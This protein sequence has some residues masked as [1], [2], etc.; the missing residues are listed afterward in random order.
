MKKTAL[1]VFAVLITLIL[2]LAVGCTEKKDENKRDVAIFM[3]HNYIS[4]GEPGDFD[5]TAEMFEEHV[6]A[7]T[8]A[9]YSCV[10][11]T[12]LINFVN[13]TG[14]LP[15]KCVV[16][17]TDDGYQSV[18]DIALPICEKY[19]AGL[20][21]AVIGGKIHQHDH[22]VPDESIAGRIELTS[23]TYSL[24]AIHADGYKGVNVPMTGEAL[25]DQLKADSDKMINEFGELFPEV[26]TIIVYPF[27]AH[28][29]EI[30]G[31]FRELGYSVSVTVEQGTATIER[32][33]PDSLRCLP[34]YQV[35][36]NLTGKDIVRIAKR[37]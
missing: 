26:G 3:Y 31:I 10:T 6:K 33:N 30:D 14:D 11:F 22:F 15:E 19:E 17:S 32:G 2:T 18:I 24:H 35:Y 4:D 7:L 23:H 29:E 9:G 5:I 1:K 16:L 21:C 27:G 8:E 34:R 20:T 36:P 28:T 25:R 13:G 37:K 12:D